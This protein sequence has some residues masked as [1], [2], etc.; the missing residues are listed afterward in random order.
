MDDN[1]SIINSTDFN[2]IVTVHIHILRRIREK[3]AR[4]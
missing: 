2:Q 1:L 4:D 3:K